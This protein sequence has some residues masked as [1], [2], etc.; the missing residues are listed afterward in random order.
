M[1]EYELE[2]Q[3]RL[4]FAASC[5][6]ESLAR[7]NVMM[8]GIERMGTVLYPRGIDLSW[9]AGLPH[10]VERERRVRIGRG[11]DLMFE[12]AEMSPIAVQG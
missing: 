2:I 4:R 8:R 9:A 3:M 7:A 10:L 5:R 12:T 11:E 6:Q 1:K